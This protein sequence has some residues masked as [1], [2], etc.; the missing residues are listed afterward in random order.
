MVNSELSRSY[1]RKVLLPHF[2]EIF[3]YIRLFSKR[4]LQQPFSNIAFSGFSM[5]SLFFSR[6]RTK[7][8]LFRKRWSYKTKEFKSS[9]YLGVMFW[10]TFL[11]F[12]SLFLDLTLLIK[13]GASFTWGMRGHGGSWLGSWSAQSSVMLY[14]SARHLT[15]T[16]PLST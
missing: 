7:F 16:L 11:G 8:Q 13:T 9:G 5:C 14:S 4:N 12:H 3:F 6:P 1:F 2:F 10:C 15:L